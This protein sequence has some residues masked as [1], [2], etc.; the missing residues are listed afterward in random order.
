MNSSKRRVLV[1]NLLFWSV[2]ALLHPLASL[3]DAGSGETP[4]IFSLFIPLAFIGLAYGST[5]LL[6]RA[7][8]PQ[9]IPK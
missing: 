6:W 2:A 8:A 1:V 5:T 3:L 4:K 7:I 9:E